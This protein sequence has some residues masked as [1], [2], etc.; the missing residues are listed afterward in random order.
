MQ[1]GSSVGGR[2]GSISHTHIRPSMAVPGKP[3]ARLT[4][5]LKLITGQRLLRFSI[6][7][8]IPAVPRK[9]REA[10]LRL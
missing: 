6:L 1:K 10:I 3:S 7:K 5:D 8:D 2:R 4:R 9:A